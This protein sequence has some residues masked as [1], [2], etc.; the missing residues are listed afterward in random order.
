MTYHAIAKTTLQQRKRIRAG[1]DPYR[2]QAQQLGVSVA[3][4]ATWKRRGDFHDRTSRPHQ[5]H[6]ALPPEAAPEV[7]WLRKDW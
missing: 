5:V 3:T 7:S 2:V 6:T 4:I 1:G